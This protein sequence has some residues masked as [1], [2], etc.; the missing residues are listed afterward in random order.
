MSPVDT[1]QAAHAGA[2]EEWV[3]LARPVDGA[4]AQADTSGWDELSIHWELPSEGESFAGF[5]VAAERFSVRTANALREA[6]ACARSLTWLGDAPDVPGPWW[7]GVAF[8]P[9][10]PGEERWADFGSARWILPEAGVATRSGRT[11][12]VAFA[13][14]S[15][16]VDVRA[17]LTQRLDALEKRLSQTAPAE[18]LFADAPAPMSSGSAPSPSWRSLMAEALSVI[19]SGKLTKVVLARPLDVSL[20]RRFTPGPVLDALRR[21]QPRCAVF[22][23]RAPNGTAF[24]GATPET[25]LRVREGWLQTEALAATLPRDA[26]LEQ[27]T[28]KEWREHYSVVDAIR[29]ALHGRVLSLRVDEAPSLVRLARLSHLRTGIEATLTPDASLAE[30]ALALHPTPA[31]A[32]E[33]RPAALEFLRAREGFDRGWYAGIVGYIGR[34]E[35]HL[36][37]ALRS[38]LV[39]DREARLFV[40]AGV[41]AGSTAEAEWAETCV[42]ATAMLE[43]LEGSAQ[44]GQHVAA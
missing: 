18:V 16:A 23:V 44:E 41:V 5:G 11:F 27:A 17:L 39:R 25:L 29:A 32:G 42:K 13:S 3:G 21:R 2:A 24:L 4:C 26:T 36:R 8:D 34:G 14:R 10:R 28:D 20:P 9:A 38:A 7:G 22:L 31:V 1:T 15:A 30:L 19:G 43:A 33:P 35:A 40:G 12:L 37:V 6:E